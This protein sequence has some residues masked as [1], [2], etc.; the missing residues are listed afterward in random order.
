M[1]ASSIYARTDC[2]EAAEGDPQLPQGVVAVIR[3]SDRYLLVRRGPAIPAADWWC[4]PGGG[5]DPGE[6]EVEALVREL[7]EELGIAVRPLRR[8][9]RAITAWGVDLAWWETEWRPEPG[10]ERFKPAP[11]EIAEVAW[12]TREEALA[13]DLLGSN[14]AFFRRT[15]RG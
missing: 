15:P 2:R 7:D 10:N 14:V 13:L 8:L 5:I 12:V 9:W 11:D 4:F 6:S 1:D 3:R